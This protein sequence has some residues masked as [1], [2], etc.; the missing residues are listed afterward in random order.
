MPCG[1][2]L[3][4]PRERLAAMQA[5]IL[6]EAEPLITLTHLLQLCRDEHRTLWEQM[7]QPASRQRVN[8]LIGDLH[9]RLPNLEGASVV[10]MAVR[11]AL[12]AALD[13]AEPVPAVVVARALAEFVDERFSHTFRV[14]FRRRS[15][16]QPGVGD[17]MPVSCPDLPGLL[18]MPLTSPPWR[19]ANR[20][21]Q[22]LHVRLAGQW[23]VQFRI[24]FDY[25][26]FDALD[27][28]VTA[29]TIIAT[30]HPNRDLA[31]FALPTSAAG[32]FPVHPVD[33]LEQQIVI[34]RL[35][36]DAVA[37]G[38]SIVVLPEL[39]V[40]ESLADH[41]RA[42][43]R[44]PAGPGL[45]VAGS[46]HS[47]RRL[48]GGP[49]PARRRNTAIAWVRGLDQPLVHEKHS[50]GDVPILEAVHAQGWPELRVYVTR[51]GWHI[52]IAI[53]RDLLNPNAVH[54]LAEA[55]ASL[56]LVPAMSQT[57]Q[58]FG[59]P[60]AQLV[61]ANQALVAVANNPAAWPAGTGR[62]PYR[63]ARA[64]VGHPGLE[65][66]TNPVHTPDTEPGAAL[67]MVGDANLAWLSAGTLADKV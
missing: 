38:A 49:V 19:L 13:P 29:N 40:T 43:V 22:T 14:S 30:C 3:L 62:P 23:A 10:D 6:Q 64:L 36:G 53:C 34:D 21:D 1:V 8:S 35:I 47:E 58:A 54:A 28:L 45:L 24:I 65:Q 20:L 55:G 41:L 66:Q 31:E 50:P 25:S 52:A 7:S 12:V 15:P 16:Y 39:C 61:G 51:D 67:L 2:H 27:G 44:R 59:A 18:D 57:L 48:G 4:A 33:L 9:R 5:A 60:A 56:V 37:A 46:Y 26:V 17:P 32:I 63:P 11:T 42:W